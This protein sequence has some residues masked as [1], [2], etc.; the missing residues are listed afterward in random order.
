MIS[1]TNVSLFIDLFKFPISATPVSST[2][3]DNF[4]VKC[5]VKYQV[6]NWWMSDHYHC[7]FISTSENSAVKSSNSF[8]LIRIMYET[9]IRICKTF[10]QNV[11]WEKVKWNGDFNK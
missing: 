9:N 2:C 11:P 3:L 1:N 10:V 5:E 7:Q 6:K 8:G 4:V